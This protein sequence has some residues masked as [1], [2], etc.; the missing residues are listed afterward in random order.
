MA[1]NGRLQYNKLELVTETITPSKAKKM[2]AEGNVDNRAMRRTVVDRYARDMRN[3]NWKLTS[4]SIKF[5]GDGTLIDGQHRLQ[6]CVEANT[7]FK[8]AVARGVEVEAREAMDTGLRRTFADVLAWKGE[9]SVTSVAAAIRMGYRWQHGNVF[10]QSFG[11]FSHAEGLDWYSRNPSIRKTIS[12]SMRLR[13]HLKLPPP[14]LSA[15]LHRINQLDPDQADAFIAQLDLGEGLVKG[16]PV[17][18]LRSWLQGQ[19]AKHAAARLNADFYLAVL[20]KSW[21]YWA[22]GEPLEIVSFKRGGTFKESMPK[23]LDFEGSPVPMVDELD[24]PVEIPV[25]EEYR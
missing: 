18:A 9:T 3:G 14:A 24:E 20:I 1:S 11:A 4:D 10:G 12:L 15:F 2:L 25:P 17:Y 19:M 16:D 21:N 8:T 22:Q 13:N 5:N 6:A 7:S 23:L